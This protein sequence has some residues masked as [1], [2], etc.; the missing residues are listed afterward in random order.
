ME[1]GYISL[2]LLS[3]PPLFYITH[4]LLSLQNLHRRLSW[5]ASL[6]PL[7]TTTPEFMFAA[8][9]STKTFSF[10]LHVA[11]KSNITSS[12]LFFET[13]LFP[14]HVLLAAP[15]RKRNLP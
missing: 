14:L 15:A 4:E 13:P 7:R 8:S 3:L 5:S 12:W 6:L 9:P 11:R 2:L 10:A 1:A